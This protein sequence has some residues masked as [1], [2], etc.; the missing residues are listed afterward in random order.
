MSQPGPGAEPAV[1]P[2]ALRIVLFGPPGAGK[3]SLLGALAESARSQQHLLNGTL[4]DP[5]HG[6]A[7]L[8]NQLYGTASRRTGDEVAPYPVDF[9]PFS[10]AGPVLAGKKH[11][12]AEVIDCDG[13]IANTLL[14]SEQLLSQQSPQGALARELVRANALLLIVD[15]SGT[16]PQMDAEFASFNH[17]LE[18]LEHDRGERVEVSGLPVFLVLTKCDLLARPGESAGSWMER[19]EER[20]RDVDGLFRE[21]L[22]RRTSRGG[23]APFGGIDV[24]VWATA[25]KRPALAG[26]PARDT[27]PFGVA[28]LFRQSLEQ[29]LVHGDRQGRSRRRLAWTA[30]GVIGVAATMVAL[31]LGLAVTN[32]E[33]PAS[34][35]RARVRQMRYG[36][37]AAAERLKGTP[38]E[39]RHRLDDLNAL[40]QDPLFASLRSADRD[41]VHGRIAELERYIPYYEKVSQV[42]RPGDVATGEKLRQ[43]SEELQSL[44][45]PE[46]WALTDADKLR[47]DRLRE[48]DKLAKAVAQVAA[49]YDEQAQKGRDL[50]VFD[51][52]LPSAE[53]PAIDWRGWYDAAA[54]L[55]DP[56]PTTP[57]DAK[58]DPIT[59]TKLTYASALRFDRVTEARSELETVKD[60]LRRVVEVAAALGLVGDVKERPPL[61]VIPRPPSFALDSAATRLK[62]LQAAYPRYPNDFTLAG[63]PDAIVSEVRQA[64][65]ANYGYLLAPAREALLKRLQASGQDADSPARWADVGA[66]LGRGPQELAAWRVLAL[67]LARLNDPKAVDPVTSMSDFLAKTSFPIEIRQIALE[68]PFRYSDLKPLAGAEFGIYHPATVADGPAIACVAAGDGDRDDARKVTVYT[69]RARDRQRLTYRPAEALWAALAL[70][71]GQSL[72]WTQGRSASFQFD[73]LSQP[74]RLHRT[75]EP[76][77]DGTSAEGIDLILSPSDGVP[78]VPDLMPVVRPAKS[79]G[80]AP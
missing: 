73:R 5:T 63:L 33:D 56:G 9:Q 17:F 40:V 31:M 47:L 34:E 30:G 76:N 54:R 37:D 68:I 79:V 6:L 36:A 69:F 8:R 44:A 29:A 43:I 1:A 10:D 13:Q 74:P 7:E 45:P 71:N 27:E 48:A 20:K 39:L 77:A 23:P 11:I 67:T 51:R 65:R 75:A 52:F 72:T 41:Y 78:R 53:S 57:S 26:S 62:E 24:H 61:L 60:K 42:T 4:A 46:E 80:R 64:A 22:A 35:L 58:N 3:T 25:I 50:W 15:A 2:D 12:G 66:W 21:F 38:T 32:R 16:L 14:A 28:E 59:G 70:R 55:L 18:L 49:W 19:I